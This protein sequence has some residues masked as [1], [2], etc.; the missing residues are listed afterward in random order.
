MDATTH[1]L[2]HVVSKGVR[3]TTEGRGH[4]TPG[5]RPPAEIVLDASE[6]F[7]PLWRAETILKW[8][9]QDRSFAL[10][11]DPEASRATVL[12]LLSAALLKWGTAAP[13]RFT[14]DDDLWDFEIVLRNASDCSPRGCV[15]ASAFFPDAGRHEL[16]IYPTMFEQ[17]PEEQVETL[18]H[19]IGHIFGLRHFFA[20]ISETAWPSQIFGTHD[21][22]SIMNYGPESILTEADRTD[23]ASLYQLAWSGHLSEI[24]G[25][26][27]RF[28]RPYSAQAEPC[29]PAVTELAPV[30]ARAAGY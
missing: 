23:L 16:V 4:A 11:A 24:N 26:P 30:A 19:E 15:L 7:I 9:F 28:V 6:G 8:R 21:K 3:C 14:R 5:G 25:T 22:F 13:V 2:E 17:D 10:A 18:V 29:T 27:V 20:N 1:E 12:E